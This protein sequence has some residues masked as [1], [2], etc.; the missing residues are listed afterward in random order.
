M[1]GGKKH[2][3]IFLVALLG[4]T[5]GDH[6]PKT[7]AAGNFEAEASILIGKTGDTASMGF[8]GQR[9]IIF[10]NDKNILV[11][12]RGKYNGSHQ[13]FVAKLTAESGYKTILGA[14]KPIDFKKNRNQRVS[15]IAMDS[16]GALHVVWYGAD[17]KA[18]INNRQVKY[19]YSA[20]GGKSWSKTKNIA[21]VSGYK[22][23]DYWQ[24]HPSIYIGQNN[25]IYIVWEGKDSKNKRQQVKFIKSLDGGASWSKWININATGNTQSRPSLVQDKSGK[26]HLIMYSSFPKFGQQIQ[27]SFSSDK[28]DSWSAWQNISNSKFD[29]RHASLTIDQN[30]TLHAV[31]RSGSSSG[32]SRVFYSKM[33]QGASWETPKQV[34]ASSSNSNYQ[35]FPNVYV[36]NNKVCVSWMETESSFN[37]PREKPLFG[38]VYL[39]YMN[40]G[41]FAVPVLMA[42]NNQSLY[43]NMPASIYDNKINF[44]PVAYSYG[45]HKTSELMLGMLHEY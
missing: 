17:T 18:Q 30:D 6:L 35:F 23:E 33:A 24:E 32:G 10:D 27:Y 2:V 12:Y 41:A 22:G 15:S 1:C 43:P 4:L 26:L 9:K 25:E 7:F 19:S 40:N 21:F 11:T 36:W 14:E 8:P 5:F 3:F 31:W 16:N 45:P 29:S 38:K 28:G 42:N 39:S 20:D 37:F 34:F 13:I 44:I